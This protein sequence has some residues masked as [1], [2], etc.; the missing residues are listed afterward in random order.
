VNN[1]T[2]TSNITT[3]GEAVTS[4]AQTIVVTDP[5]GAT[6]SSTY[7]GNGSPPEDDD[8][9]HEH[10]GGLAWTASDRAEDRNEHIGGLAW[11][12]SD[13]AEDRNEHGGDL[14][15]KGRDAD[16]DD[17]TAPV[18]DPP[19]VIASLNGPT[20]NDRGTDPRPPGDDDHH[21]NTA[22][23]SGGNVE[24]GLPGPSSLVNPYGLAPATP[25]TS[26]S[27][28]NLEPALPG[29]RSIVVPNGLALFNQFLAAGLGGDSGAPI[30]ITP[31]PIG[32]NDEQ[33]LARPHA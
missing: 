24:P 21:A 27:G 1:L 19:P 8:D 6:Q 4:A 9:D 17:R 30:S 23:A 13:H 15:W 33:F 10:G 7:P 32:S 20:Q 26:A 31:P 25:G 29:P 22:S 5:P 3:S 18:A 28:G 16:D 2:V 14:R 11:T 12:A